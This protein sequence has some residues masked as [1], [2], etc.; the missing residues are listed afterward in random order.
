MNYLQSVLHIQETGLQMATFD[1]AI[2][3][4][5]TVYDTTQPFML[6]SG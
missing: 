6:A 4:V 3:T 1:G 5:I 2:I